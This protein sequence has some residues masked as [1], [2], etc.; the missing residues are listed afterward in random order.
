MVDHPAFN[1]AIFALLLSLP[2][3]F[4]Q[5]WLYAGAS[6]MSHLQGIQICMAATL[7]D[8]VIMLIAFGIVAAVARSQDWVL[9]P[10]TS[11]VA[12]F[13]VVGLAISIAVEIVATRTDGAFSWRYTPAMPVTPL[14]GIGLAPLMMWLVVPLL[15]LWFVRRQIGRPTSV[16]SV[17][18]TNCLT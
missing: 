17:K 11:Q 8:A 4:G 5:M 10:K 7:G 18:D 1:V 16:S 15:V 9:A 3:E 6:E 12:G 14:L 13:V 2:W